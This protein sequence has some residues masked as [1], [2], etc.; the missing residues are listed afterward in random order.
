VSNLDLQNRAPTVV[1]N[2]DFRLTVQRR[3]D[4][5]NWV[6]KSPADILSICWKPLGTVDEKF[7][8]CYLIDQK[9]EGQLGNFYEPCKLP[10]VLLRTY[11]QLDGFNETQVGQPGVIIDQYNNRS[12]VID[13]YQLN[14]GT[15]TYQI[16]GTTP[17]PSPFSDCLLKTEERTNDGTLRK[18]RRTYISSG[19][20][21]QDDEIKF[22]GKVQLRTITSL[23]VEP[24]TPSGWTLINKGIDFINGRQVYKYGFV[25]GDGLIEQVI[26]SRQDGL[27]EVT[28]ISFGNKVTPSGVVLKDEYRESDGYRI[29]TVTSMQSA[30]GS[31]PASGS[32]SFDTIADFP[33]PGRV[34]AF[35]ETYGGRTMLDVFKSPPVTMRI[36]TTVT[37][38]YQTI[39]TFTPP[40]DLWAPKEWATVRAQWISFGSNPHNLVEP[41]PGYLAVSATPVTVTCS[42]VA[43]IDAA[44]FGNPIY[45]GTTA[46]ITTTGGPSNPAGTTVTLDVHIDERPAFTS[47]TGTNYYRKTTVVADIPTPPTLPV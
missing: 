36:K 34:K 8:N 27:R 4:V 21:S 20:L 1:R 37:V 29:Y 25:L 14:V 41:C 23:G 3:Y 40:S 47:I 33:Y 31:D 19:Q 24:A 38:A 46:V 15:S 39:N 22:G 44:I 26:N 13:Y 7:T 2:P 32:F 30:S 16:P 11:E 12:I 9:I 17:A 10:P 43:P 28:N 18:I 42:N 5:L 35:T 45:G 6:P